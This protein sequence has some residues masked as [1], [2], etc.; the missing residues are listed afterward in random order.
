MPVSDVF[1]ISAVRT[2]I[3]IGKP[4]GALFHYQPV[5]LAATVMA[6]AARRA[7]IGPERIEDVL[8]GI[9]TPLGDQ[10]GNLARLAALKAGFPV[11]VGGVS[12]N[13]MCGSG[14]QAVHFA[15]QATKSYLPSPEYGDQKK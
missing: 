11:S 12:I 2:A 8:W 5:E 15:A 7:E 10:G 3:G 9:V 14:Q 1:I 13:R 6:E 4:N